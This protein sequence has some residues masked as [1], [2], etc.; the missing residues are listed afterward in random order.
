MDATPHHAPPIVTLTLNPALDICTA[1]AAVTPSDK[2]RCEAART[3]PGGGGVNVAR[4]VHRLGG[5]ALAVVAAGGPTGQ[6]VMSLLAAEALVA[7]TVPIAGE[8]RQ[9][10]NVTDRG[11]GAEYRFIL[12][13]PELA[14][15][16]WTRCL[17]AAFAAAQQ[18]SF[19]VVSGSL[20]PGPPPETL[21]VF[22]RRCRQA[23]LRLVVDSSGASL[24]CALKAGVHLVK[25][26]LLELSEY[27]G[28]PLPDQA[29]RLQACRDL[30]GAGA[31][32]IV[33]LTLGAEGALLVTADQALAAPALPVKAVSTIGA[34]D[35]FLGALLWAMNRDLPLAA[36]LQHAAAA[37]AAAL[38][39][40]GAGLCRRDEVLAL[41][42][43][44]AV[45]AGTPASAFP[46]PALVRRP[47]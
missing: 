10:F 21:G 45:V 15:A 1:T 23:G 30:I 34:G 14:E 36:S 7:T 9:C 44:V 19:I 12:P 22:A 6:R 37:G 33:A 26:N 46:Q 17:E 41:A 18:A 8:T 31:A 47:R 42:E 13:G 3:A 20:P 16:E 28:R 29:A 40:P 43:R 27:V 5:E 4:V 39:S 25:P 32:E 38:M 35:S 11:S 24:A 2:L